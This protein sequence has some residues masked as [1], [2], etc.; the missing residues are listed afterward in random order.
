MRWRLCSA[1]GLGVSAA[2]AAS[3]MAEAGVQLLVCGPC[4]CIATAR[5]GRRNLLGCMSA[6]GGHCHY[7]REE[8]QGRKLIGGLGK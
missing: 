4:G 5:A 6:A 7:I 8:L 1:W 2:T 3:I